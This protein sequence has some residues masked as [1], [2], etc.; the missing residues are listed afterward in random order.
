[1]SGQAGG[2]SL[3]ISRFTGACENDN[4]CKVVSIFPG[5][6]SP[7]SDSLFS[8]AEESRDFGDVRRNFPESPEW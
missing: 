7:G 3:H 5:R 2:T 4:V 1:M 6:Q 8:G